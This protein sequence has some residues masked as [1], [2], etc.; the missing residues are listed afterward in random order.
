MSFKALSCFL[1]DD[2]LLLEAFES[3]FKKQHFVEPPP[4]E[5][6]VL[7]EWPLI[8]FTFD[9][10]VKDYIFFIEFKMPISESKEK[11][12]SCS[13]KLRMTFAAHF[14]TQSIT[15]PEQTKKKRCS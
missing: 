2:F 15:P 10:H 13:V 8:P 3:E 1:I 7:F 9:R 4:L 11:V 6:H 12:V 14:L 5:C